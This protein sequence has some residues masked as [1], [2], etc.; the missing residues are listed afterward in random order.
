MIAHLLKIKKLAFV[1]GLS[2]SLE[3]DQSF[4]LRVVSLT[5]RSLTS[6][7]VPL[8][9]ET[10]AARVYASFSQPWYKKVQYA[11]IYF[12]LS[13]TDQEKAVKE[14]TQHVRESTSEAGEQDVGET[15]VNRLWGP[16][17]GGVPDV[18]ILFFFTCFNM[19]PREE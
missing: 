1:C 12:V 19:F 3:G 17:M 5:S 7:V 8:R 2:R 4:R 13:A 18:N 15:T 11:R 6:Y 9:N 10:S 14:L 16:L